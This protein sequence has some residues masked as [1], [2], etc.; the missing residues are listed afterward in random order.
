MAPRIR[1]KDESECLIQGNP[2]VSR[3]VRIE[4]FNFPEQEKVYVNESVLFDL[5]RFPN[6]T[7]VNGPGYT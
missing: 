1:S 3:P 7:A 5:G 6:A 2:N 4:F